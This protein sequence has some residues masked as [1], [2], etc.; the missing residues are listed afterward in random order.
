LSEV[1]DQIEKLVTPTLE[2][3]KVELVDLTYGKSQ[4]GWTLCFYMDKP[5]GFAMTDC[6]VWSDRLGQMIDEA[7]VVDRSYVLEVSS[8]GLD[9]PLRKTA[10]FQK[11]AGQRVDVK[12]YAALNGQKNFHGDLLGGDDTEIR[13]KTDEGHEVA[14][15][16]SQIAKCRLDPDIT[17]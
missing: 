3:E 14:L 2:A 15:Q 12:L 11:F 5:G 8:P 7:G 1:I 13:I 9:R 4:G 17:F 16:R 10:D 6:E